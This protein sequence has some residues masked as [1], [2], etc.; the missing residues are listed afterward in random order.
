MKATGIKSTEKSD[1]R[2][3]IA[4]QT[5]GK[6]EKNSAKCQNKQTKASKLIITNDEKSRRTDPAGKIYQQPMIHMVNNKPLYTKNPPESLQQGFFIFMIS[7]CINQSS[8][9][10][11]SKT[12]TLPPIK[13]ANHL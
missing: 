6:F 8:H 1:S 5:A 12:Q 7:S 4:R 11:F 3:T 13:Q 9:Y 2:K 10:N